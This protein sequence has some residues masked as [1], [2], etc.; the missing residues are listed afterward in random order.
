M[1]RCRAL[2]DRLAAHSARLAAKA[3]AFQ[4][5][6]EAT[7]QGL[8]SIRHELLAWI[9]GQRIT[10]LA[11]V[12][13]PYGWNDRPP[14]G[15][16]EEEWQ[17]LTPLERITI[18]LEALR[19]A[20]PPAEVKPSIPV[21]PPLSPDPGSGEFGSMEPTLADYAFEQF[22]LFGADGWEVGLGRPDAARHMRH[23][24]EGSGEPL[25]VDLARLLR[26]EPVFQLDSQGALA[27]FLHDIQ[28]QVRGEYQGQPLSLQVTSPWIQAPYGRSDNWFF[29]MGGW[30]YAYSAEVNMTPPPTPD[31][32]PTV[33]IEYQIHLW[34]Y[35]NWDTGK[36]VTIPR[37]IPGTDMPVSL[38]IPEEYQPHNYEVG[39]NWVVKDTGPARLH[40]AGLAREYEITGVTEVIRLNYTLD[41]NSGLL[42]P[43]P[44]P[45][46]ATAPGR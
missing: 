35:Y 32:S 40:L 43:S 8:A 20:G 17:G 11:D 4:T 24:L 30:S 2:A 26:D 13:L 14:P 33:K 15:V 12:V 31:G 23:Y 38:P 37:T 34:D 42:M 5:V 7:L 29:A 45:E 25:E 18:W 27:G 19:P 44:G 16:P 3:E 9:H 36:S 10:P 22:L 21:P 41:P 28:T 6:D 1:A 46:Q 39:D